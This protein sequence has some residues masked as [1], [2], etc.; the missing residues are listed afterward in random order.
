MSTTGQ[1][2]IE[3]FRDQHADFLTTPEVA[4]Y[5]GVSESHARAFA[6]LNGVQKAE[7]PSRGC[8]ATS[9]TWSAW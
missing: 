3:H 8:P 1:R 4:R 9:G 7:T 6:A 2:I 5:V